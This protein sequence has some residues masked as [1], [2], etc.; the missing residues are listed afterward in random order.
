MGR[1][2]GSSQACYFGARPAGG[3]C[4]KCIRYVNTRRVRELRTP[5]TYAFNECHG[6]GRAGQLLAARVRKYQGTA[7]GQLAVIRGIASQRGVK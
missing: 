3:T 7:K 5:G 1:S 6:I 4:D 2:H